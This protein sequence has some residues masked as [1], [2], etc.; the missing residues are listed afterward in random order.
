MITTIDTSLLRVGDIV[1]CTSASVPAYA[2][3]LKELNWNVFKAGD[4]TVSTHTAI[5]NRSQLPDGTYAWGLHEM[6]AV[7]L[8]SALLFSP[9]SNYL[10]NGNGGERMVTILRHPA[11]DNEAL[12]NKMELDLWKL[13]AAGIKYDWAGCLKNEFSFLKDKAGEYYCCELAEHEADLCGFSYF[14]DAPSTDDDCTPYQ[15]QCGKNLIKVA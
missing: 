15:L 6:I 13:W 12:R 1:P 2:I 3:R 4:L 8:K 10:N 7:G 5:I 11:L 14:R 9:L